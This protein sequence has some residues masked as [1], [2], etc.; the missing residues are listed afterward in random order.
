MLDSETGNIKSTVYPPPTPTFI[1]RILYN[2]SL[3]R[4]IL[5]LKNGSLCI[6][7]VFN[8]DTAT[9]ELMQNANMLKDGSGKL[10][11]SS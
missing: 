3:S 8:R 11:S 6:Y 7:K 2:M 4:L 10:I 9:L 1:D 5:L